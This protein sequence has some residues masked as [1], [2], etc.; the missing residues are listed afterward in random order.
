MT[1]ESLT[2]L[3][4]YIISFSTSGTGSLALGVVVTYEGTSFC[5]PFP[6]FIA[7][8]ASPE[9]PNEIRIHTNASELIT[10]QLRC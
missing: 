9:H 10:I 4:K 7:C 6:G 8:L 2:T 3:L 5:Y 1:Q